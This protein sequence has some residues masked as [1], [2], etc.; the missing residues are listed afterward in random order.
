MIKQF[1]RWTGLVILLFILQTTAVP[2]IAIFGI[3]PD[4]LI[5]VLFFIGFKT[6]VI[7]AVFAGFFLGLA[8]DFYS[9]Q[10]LGQTALAKTI[11]G[12]FAGLCN[13]KVMRI[14]PIFQLVLLLLMFIIHDA[15]FF[16][17]QMAK[18]STPIQAVG[19]EIISSTLP[20]ALY[21]LF[22]ALIPAFREY[23]FPSS[24]RR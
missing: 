4:L 24:G 19:L 9:P 16:A 13:E 12:Y 10:I 8:Q 5:L 14:D 20:R 21:T 6:D 11:A 23:L 22:F 7:P 15:V 2:L 17:V 1:F 18:T 3:T